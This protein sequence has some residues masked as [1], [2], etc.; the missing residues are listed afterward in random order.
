M[1]RTIPLLFALILSLHDP[2]SGQT[3]FSLA[4]QPGTATRMGFGARGIGMGNAMSAL[5]S[6]ETPGYYNPALAPFQAIPSGHAAFGFLPLDRNLNTLNY[7]QRLPPTAGISFG[8]INAGVGDLEGRNRDGM[9]TETYSTSENVFLLSFGT[10]VDDNTALGISTKIFYYS[11]FEGVA[12]TT[13]GFDIGFLTSITEDLTLGIVIQDI[14]SKYKWDTSSL[15]GQSG[16]TT[17][18]KFPLRRKIGLA[19]SAKP[20]E[21][22]VTGEVEWIGSLV[23][24][25]LGLE[26]ELLEGVAVRGG[27]DQISFKGDIDSK[28]SLG[29]SL[30]T[31][32]ALW[33]PSVHYAYV[34][35][36]YAPG[37]IHVLSIKLNFE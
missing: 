30:Q 6:G 12:S 17:I 7:S 8:I 32:I 2:V 19:Y 35:E 18:E 5:T 28:P 9:V 16:N 1:T 4:G 37:G 26:K 23:L 34:I 13:V 21:A 31:P 33:K 22:I 11:L 27:V 10:K 14:N 25:R 15:Y 20:F 29:F 3:S 36:P 24:A